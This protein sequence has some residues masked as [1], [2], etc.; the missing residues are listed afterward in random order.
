LKILLTGASGFVGSHILDA[1]RAH[2]LDTAILLRPS[3]NRA[4]IAAHLARGKEL[5]PSA[6]FEVEVRIGSIG[7]PESLR[8]AMAGITHVVHCAGATKARRNAEFYEV[9]QVGTQNVVSAVNAQKVTRLIHISSLAAAGPAVAE[10]PAREDDPP[11]PVSVY[12][13]S[14]LAG[15]AE[16]RGQAKSEFVILRP[17]A[18]Y[19]PRDAEFLRLFK[20]IKRHLLPQ[21]GVRQALS[22]VFVRDLAEAVVR[23]LELHGVAGKTFFVAGREAVTAATLARRIVAQIKTW[24]I[25]LP[26]PTVFF[27]PICL[28]QELMTRLTGKANVLSLQKYAELS[29]PGWV[30]DPS[31][32]EKETGNICSTSLDAGIAQTLTWYR[33][34]QW[35]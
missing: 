11:R 25:P 10:K 26:L 16:V 32:F 20:A 13:E 1:L 30:C 27:W 6:R 18:V 4:F 9:N 12:G 17:P 14:K 24:T 19:G 35:L 34:N 22:L 2:N 28:A 15:E 33:E 29:A 5:Q 3:S 21:T 7:D 31:R 8:K 23:S